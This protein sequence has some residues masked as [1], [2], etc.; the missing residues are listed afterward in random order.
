MGFNVFVTREIPKAGLDIVHANC[1]P[2]EMNPHD[3]VLTRQ[4]LLDGV[5]GILYVG[6]FGNGFPLRRFSEVAGQKGRCVRAGRP[7]EYDVDR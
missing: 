6:C 3:R 4:E 2:V 1:D 7:E 5:R